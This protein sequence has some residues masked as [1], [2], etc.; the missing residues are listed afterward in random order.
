M[1]QLK[2]GLRIWKQQHDE[3]GLCK[4]QRSF[5]DALALRHVAASNC[6]EDFSRGLVRQIK[7][8][9][10]W[11][12][13]QKQKEKNTHEKPK[14]HKKEKSNHSLANNTQRIKIFPENT[15]QESSKGTR[16]LSHVLT[17]DNISM[18][19]PKTVSRSSRYSVVILLKPQ[20]LRLGVAA[21]IV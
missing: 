10:A 4:S 5:T 15:S 14:E 16:P 1:N 6:S 7:I 21:S 11:K 13:C 19:T 2:P 9:D 18:D 12:C 8:E 3:R 17:I 20:A